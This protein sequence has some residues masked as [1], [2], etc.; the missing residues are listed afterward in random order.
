MNVEN[1]RECFLKGPFSKE[2][3]VSIVLLAGDASD[4]NYFRI[5]T[6][7]RS[8]IVCLNK[9][10][11]L[12]RMSDFMDVQKIFQENGVN[13]PTIYDFNPKSGYFILEDLGNTTLLKK[14]AC[15][16]ED[17][18]ELNFYK[19]AIE[20][21]LKINNI[22]GEKYN[23]SIF[24]K[25]FDCEKLMEEVIF[26]FNHLILGLMNYPLKKEDKKILISSYEDICEKIS[27]EK[28]V[29]NHRDFHSRNLMLHSDSVFVVD[30]QD[31]RMGIPQYDLAS[32]LDDCYYEMSS[33][34]R[35][36]LKKYYFNCLSGYPDDFDHFLKLYDYVKMQRLFKALGSFSYI[37]Q[38]K[39]EAR[40][41]KYIGHGFEK[42]RATLKK[43]S[44]FDELKVL[45][46]KVYYE[47]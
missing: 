9:R 12:E 33:D 45:I 14:F 8:C 25:A 29:L 35:I 13:V 7:N 39:K 27:K 3:I 37:Y 19:M 15:L 23:C 43:Y 16:K 2:K 47:N 28:R 40:Y 38:T 26:S 21:L 11:D 10:A 36:F 18:D 44:K 17:C 32:L 4:R 30:F 31:A 22:D 41:L 6:K 42:L 24:Q 20:Q 46:S 1:A 5:V 34:N